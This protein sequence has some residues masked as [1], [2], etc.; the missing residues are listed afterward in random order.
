MNLGDQRG[1]FTLVG[2]LV[3][4]TLFLIVLGATL[5][6]FSTSERIN[7]DTQTREDA[8]DRARVTVDLLSRQLRNM[9]SP[10]PDQPQ[11]IDRATATDVIFQTVDP[12]GPNAGTNT[13]NVKRVRYCLDGSGQLLVQNQRWTG[14]VPVV[15]ANGGTATTAGTCP[16]SGWDDQKVVADN[17]TNYVNGQ[18]RPVFTF[19]PSSP[20]TAIT[21]VHADVWIDL[22]ATRPPLETSLSSGVFLRNQNRQPTAALTYTSSVQGIYLNGSSSQDPEGDPLLY[23]WYDTSLATVSASAAAPCDGGPFLGAGVTILDVVAVGASRNVYLIVK[24]PALLSNQS[25]TTLVTNSP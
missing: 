24:D 5:N 20:L 22:D 2:L 18:T 19:N 15:P 23:C 13:A 11:S 9:A 7:R 16:G 10:T 4:M 25:A 14:A 17:V 1:E 12:I 8:M 3:A 6:L 21:Q